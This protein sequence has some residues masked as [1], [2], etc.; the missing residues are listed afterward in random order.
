M[1]VTMTQRSN[2]EPCQYVIEGEMTIYNALELKAQLLSPLEQ[3]AQME[4]DLAGVTE[5]DSAG[6]QLLLMAKTEARA[7]G[8]NLAITGHSTAV[9]EVLDLCNLEGF[10]GDPVLVR[11]QEY[12]HES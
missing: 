10:F 12:S 2:T 11:S 1:T 9:L 4:V 3:C 6:L 8:K 7:R 5:M